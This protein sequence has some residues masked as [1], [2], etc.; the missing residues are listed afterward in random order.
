MTTS[1][2][3]GATLI[4]GASLLSSIYGLIIGAPLFFALTTVIISLVL[5]TLFTAHETHRW[6]G[7]LR[8]SEEAITLN[9]ELETSKLL[10]EKGVDATN[11]AMNKINTQSVVLK[12]QGSLIDMEAQL[13]NQ[14][15]LKLVV[16]VDNTK[17]NTDALVEQET[18]MKKKLSTDVF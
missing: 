18:I 12:E 14:Q 7:A 17:I 11:E 10:L 16:I 5:H 6:N 15:N 8:F 9:K 3:Q 2:T 1:L 13:F 4:V